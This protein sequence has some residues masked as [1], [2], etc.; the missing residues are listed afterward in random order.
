M[1]FTS[2]PMETASVGA[3]RHVWQLFHDRYPAA[4]P[5]DCAAAL[6]VSEAELLASRCG[7]DVVRLQAAAEVLQALPSLGDVRAV[8]AGAHAELEADCCFTDVRLD[9]RGGSLRD[10]GVRLTFVPAHWRHVFAI[11]PV[12]S[13]GRYGALC[14]FGAD[15]KALHEIRLTARSEP[16]AWRALLGRHAAR[17]QHP[18]FTPVAPPAAASHGDHRPVDQA[19]LA[20]AW[21]AVQTP[22]DA[23]ALCGRAGITRL[24]ALRALGAPWAR[25]VP[26][27]TLQQ[28]LRLAAA[29][30]TRLT[31]TAVNRACLQARSGPVDVLGEADGWFSVSSDDFRLRLRQAALDSAWIVRVPTRDG[32]VSSLEVYDGRCLVASVEAE[33]R[34]G[35][36][37]PADWRR[38]LAHVAAN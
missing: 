6:G 32:L 29:E 9:G 13:A 11:L 34:P 17:S 38:L 37:E 25:R 3:L 26:V 10:G 31:L 20:A 14:F 23:G 27:A 2:R 28:T 8:T 36:R 19:A 30:R 35:R 7:G 15:G 33:R 21:S 12:R 5:H 22:Q 4:R 18:A 1:L 24:Q 16:A